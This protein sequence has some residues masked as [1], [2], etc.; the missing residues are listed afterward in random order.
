MN[1]ALYVF[2]SFFAVMSSQTPVVEN[3]PQEEFAEALPDNRQASI[4]AVARI[5]GSVAD[6][7]IAELADGIVVEL[8]EPSMQGIDGPLRVYA[9]LMNKKT[10]ALDLRPISVRDE[11]YE[12]REQLADGSWRTVDP[13]PERTFTGS[14]SG[15]R[16]GFV[17]GSLLSEGML[18]EVVF[19]DGKRQWIQPLSDIVSGAAP[20]LHV[21]YDAA[22]TLCEGTCGTAESTM[23]YPAA[24]S[25]AAGTCGGGACVAQLA[26][27]ADFEYYTARGSNSHNTQDRI[28]A[29]INVMNHQYVR[30][31]QITHVITTVL[32]RTAEPDP[33][34][35]NVSD[36]L[37]CQFITE[38][39]DNQ[40]AVVRDL[41]KLFTGR[42]ISGS[43]V[44]QAA[45]TNQICDNNGFCTA[46]LDN[47]AYCY[48]QSDF[49]PTFACQ[50]DVAAHQIGHL[51]GAFDCNCPNSTMNS[52]IS[53]ANTFGNS[54]GVSV[55]EIDAHADQ[56]LCLAPLN[57]PPANNTCDDAIVLPG[58]GTFSGSNVNSGT[59]GSTLNCGI[60]SGDV[61]G[62]RNDVYFRI[63]AIAN[64]TATV[65][66]CGSNYDTMLS[67]HTVCPATP[68]NQVV[69]N[70][71]CGGACNFNS[72]LT[73]PATSGTT[74]Y[75]RVSG[76]AGATG[77]ITLNVSGPFT[78][79]NN[80]CSAAFRLEDGA[81]SEGSLALATND[82]S[83]GCGSSSVNPD[84]WYVFTANECGGVLAVDACGT[85][86]RQGQDTGM[87]TV[88]SMHTACPGTTANQRVCVDD[89]SPGCTGD[90]GL[91]R[92]SRAVTTLLPFEDTLVR[93]SHFSTSLDDG[94]FLVHA[95]FTPA[96]LAP[97]VTGIG[98]ATLDCGEPYTGPTPS[99]TD[100]NC[101]TPVTWSLVTS[102]TGMAINP[103]TG[104][105]SWATPTTAG[106]PHQVTI[107][108]TNGTSF[109]DESWFVTVNR[110]V[111][112][113][114]PIANESHDCGG[115]YTGP[116]PHLSNGSCM[117]PATW[118]LVS[119]PAGMTINS[120]TGVVSWP[121]PAI[122]GSPHVITIRAVNTAGQDDESWNLTVDRIAPVVN[123]ILN[124][125]ETCD[126]PFV[127]SVPSLRDPSCMLPAAWSLDSGP[128]G[129][130]I[131]RGSGVIS[132]PRPVPGSV[133]T[134]VIRATNSR[135]FDQEGWRLAINSAAPVVR[136]IPNT[137]TTCGREYIGP[138]PGLV[139]ADCVIDV[140]WSLIGGP[141]GISIDPS[142]G[143]VR[144][145]APTSAESGVA[146]VIRATSDDGFD[147]ESWRIAVDP[148][149]PVIAAIPDAEIPAFDLYTGSTPNL[150]NSEC[151][152][153]IDTWSLIDGPDDMIID[154][155]AGVVKWLSPTR[156]GSPHTVT[157]RGTNADGSDDETW[158]LTVPPLTCLSACGD[159]DASNQVDLLDFALLARCFGAFTP[160][161]N[162]PLALLACADLD[163]SGM[164][165]LN[166]YARFHFALGSAPQGMPPDCD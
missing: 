98:N 42:D 116:N 89:S 16:E 123:D 126:P 38:W 128:T 145:P 122:A 36:T 61:G 75:I 108:A 64:G 139:N 46:G 166:D 153:D 14:V 87:D 85:H 26:V 54:G 69:C 127:G 96:L 81:S 1:I 143:V 70:D 157:I 44:G 17:A 100:F 10:I 24:G 77:S 94:F 165:D 8:V 52:T 107:R 37:M 121:N 48:S 95:N 103:L 125:T 5:V 50:T 3:P 104:V 113:I 158:T 68:V 57:S 147:D 163:G 86:D 74:Y 22:D 112:L 115:A 91:I 120:A 144:W 41:A 32:V 161:N 6:F 118:S 109:D 66:L 78:P 111:P 58:S 34:T 93:V 21:V 97:V 138:T 59:D 92:D 148:V 29:I 31:V 142:T 13:G 105:V 129:M 62:G 117:V 134:I 40:T 90:A 51:W 7:A 99:V 4:E 71:D 49:S 164:V 141:V 110:L 101:M 65:D 2:A 162:C 25:P 19:S 79:G 150:A 146:V 30:E 53:C 119:G 84:V 27:D 20:G 76:Y 137:Q 102:P 55:S 160:T 63:T 18:A 132:W 136:D 33:Y 35:S 151:A 135:G 149:G 152:E 133:S 12:L 11:N 130:D 72:C 47:G 82:G 156:L 28:H 80:A 124:S 43:N 159:L 73:F 60:L 131:D 114:V 9:P 45:N 88:I 83:A 39:T 15:E 67:I 106:S 140:A 155:R 23:Y 154:P 56:V